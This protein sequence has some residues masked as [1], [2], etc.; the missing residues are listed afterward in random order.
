M[1]FY[2]LTFGT[3]MAPTYT[4][5]CRRPK[6]RSAAPQR[7]VAVAAPERPRRARA[8][9]CTHSTTRT[10]PLSPA[11]LAAS[12]KNRGESGRTYTP[13]PRR[14]RVGWLLR[15]N[16]RAIWFVSMFIFDTTKR[17][18]SGCSGAAVPKKSAKRDHRTALPFWFYINSLSLYI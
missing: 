14:A 13:Y 11:A 7:C 12:S 8:A 5:Q 18:T 3:L 10:R 9:A 15:P 6:T 1:C 16:T 2:H 4:S 17:A